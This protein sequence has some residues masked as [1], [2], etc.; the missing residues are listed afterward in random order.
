MTPL[1]VD[2]SVSA[3]WLFKDEKD[4]HAEQALQ[5]LGEAH[6][7]VPQLWHYEM[8][9]IML[10]AQRRGRL[11]QDGMIS[12]INALDDLP[13]ETDTDPDLDYA[14]T[15]AEAHA[16]SF[17]DAF[18]LELA[19]R[20]QARLSSLDGQLVKAARSKGVKIFE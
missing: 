3:S 19:L 6:G 8:R 14:L 20:R 18:Y 4:L 2:A 16:L 15:L 7:L 13:L 1:V 17:Y 9:N 11:S 12:R 10:V 5:S